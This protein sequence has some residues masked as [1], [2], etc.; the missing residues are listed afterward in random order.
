[1][2]FHQEKSNLNIDELYEKQKQLLWEYISV[3]NS[4][5]NKCVYKRI[6]IKHT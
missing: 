2:K 5:I 4:T 1:M 6:F 3:L